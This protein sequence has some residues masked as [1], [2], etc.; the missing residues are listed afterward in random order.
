VGGGGEAAPGRDIFQAVRA[1]TVDA[2]AFGTTPTRPVPL[3]GIKYTGSRTFSVAT[4][5]IM[6]STSKH[7]DVVHS[8]KHVDAGDE[9]DV[10]A[11]RTV[12][13]KYQ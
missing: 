13:S 9:R 10:L 11:D 1:V 12:L 8:S 3:P 4:P 7:V 2:A 6:V 5:F